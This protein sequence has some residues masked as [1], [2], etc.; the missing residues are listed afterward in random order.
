M[1][2]DSIQPL[3]LLWPTLSAV[4]PFAERGIEDSPGYPPGYLGFFAFLGVA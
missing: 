2:S 3:Q 4:K 1:S